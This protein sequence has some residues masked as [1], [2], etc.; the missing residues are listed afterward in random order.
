VR[1]PA[2][3]TPI[4]ILA[5][6]ELS[7][8]HGALGVVRSA[9]SLGI[10][11]FHA[12]AGRRSPIDRSRYSSGSLALPPDATAEQRLQILREFSRER[13]RAVLLPVDD[14]SV[15][16]VEDHA[17]ALE[18]AFLFPRQPSGLAH[19]LADKREMYRLCLRHGVHTP[20]SAFPQ[21]VADVV[22]H[23]DR[24]D[25]PVV[26][27]RIDASQP[28]APAAPNVRIAGSR[29]ELLDAYTLMESPR[30]PNVMLQE[31]L[32]D[33]SDS[34]WMFNGY[35]DARSE[36]GVAFTGRKLRQS[37]PYTGAAT[38]GVCAANP[39]VEEITRRFLRAVGYRGIVDI[40]YRLD[41]RD[42]RYKLLDVNPRIGASFRLFVA[43]DGMDVLRAMYLDLTGREVPACAQRDGRR[44][45]VEPQDLLSSS[46]YIR[47]GDLS[48]RAWA[49]SLRHVDEAAWWAREDPQP[50]IA[51]SRWLFADRL[52][53]RLVRPWPR[54]HD[55][56]RTAGA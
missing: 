14:A 11:V 27:K 40:D 4:L 37:P 2:G 16:F 28:A 22:E 32:P 44:W 42:E 5:L 21:S 53:K 55:S 1:E 9:G 15:M 19:A 30:L 12:H 46:T 50:F 43:D 36:C 7:M 18:D 49:R 34:N 20:L 23:A 8:R 48:V 45:I 47:C 29:E 56:S 39:V 51:L 38:L 52:R 41:H 6:A 35:F 17:G 24:A 54:S 3:E 13:G 33:A 25:F 10:P 31:Y 26:V